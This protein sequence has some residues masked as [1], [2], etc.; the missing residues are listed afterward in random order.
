MTD[1]DCP[2]CPCGTGHKAC[3]CPSPYYER[4]ACQGQVWRVVSG[5]E[6]LFVGEYTEALAYCQAKGYPSSIIYRGRPGLREVPA[7]PRI[8][9]G[10]G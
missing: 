1:C 6:T 5:G 4:P 2:S 8:E 9:T 3:A 10:I 7:R